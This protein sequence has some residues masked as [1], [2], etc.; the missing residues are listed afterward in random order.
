MGTLKTGTFLSP[1]YNG[2]SFITLLSFVFVLQGVKADI[3]VAA[4]ILYIFIILGNVFSF[5]F[6]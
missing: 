5:L 6:P 2:A 1:L 3:A 4:F